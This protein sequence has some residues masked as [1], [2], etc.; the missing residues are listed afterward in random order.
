MRTPIT[1]L[2]VGDVGFGP[3]RGWKGWAA[4]AGMSVLRDDVRYPHCFMVVASAYGDTAPLGPRAVE[5]MPGGARS[6]EISDRWTSEYL[7][8]RPPYL[9]GAEHVAANAARRMI[10]L[11]YGYMNYPYL[12][13]NQLHIESRLIDWY[14]SRETEDGYPAAPICSQLVDHAL[15]RGGV[16]LFDDGRMEHSV[17]TGDVFYGLTRV[18]GMFITP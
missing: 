7:Y 4:R 11:P 8:V 10:G 17:T 5:A 12:A 16:Q 9:P 15:H 18:G 3:I 13:L 14:V 2:R 6:V 1:S